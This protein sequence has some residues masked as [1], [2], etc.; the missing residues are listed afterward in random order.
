[1]V[2]T[3]RV[4]DVHKRPYISERATPIMRVVLTTASYLGLGL[5]GPYR[6]QILS[7][8]TAVAAVNNHTSIVKKS[9]GWL[10]YL[11]FWPLVS[12]QTSGQIY[13]SERHSTWANAP[14]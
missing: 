5:E 12:K 9:A 6:L 13:A 1:M 2:P 14:S 11:A 7:N 4:R 3:A 8:N 10:R